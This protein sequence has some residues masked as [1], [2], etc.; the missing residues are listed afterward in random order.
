MEWGKVIALVI[1]IPIILFPVSFI[2]YMNIGGIYAAV[3]RA[4]KRREIPEKEM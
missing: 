3:K 2:W 1:G 4:R